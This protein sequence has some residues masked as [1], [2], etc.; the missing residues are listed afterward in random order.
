MMRKKCDLL[1]SQRV[2]FFQLFQ[3]ALQHSFSSTSPEFK[4]NIH[5]RAWDCNSVCICGSDEDCDSKDRKKSLPL[6][7]PPPTNRALPQLPQH[8]FEFHESLKFLR[9]YLFGCIC[10]FQERRRME[11]S[12]KS[13]Q[14]HVVPNVRGKVLTIPGRNN[15]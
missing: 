9:I 2:N 7:N 8:L 15:G 12:P 14:V 10:S 3:I 5:R 4:D 1:K 6:C 11:S 13:G